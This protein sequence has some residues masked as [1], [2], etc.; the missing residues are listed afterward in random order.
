AL[1]FQ[2]ITHPDDL[3]ADLLLLERLNRGE[4]A[5]YRMDKRYLRADGSTVW[6]HLTASA[7]RDE[8]GAPQIYIA[9]VQDQTERR[10][11]EAELR[12]PREYEGRRKPGEAGAPPAA[13][14]EFLA[15]MSHEIRTPL[16]AILGFTSL[17]GERRELGE[18]AHGHVSRISAAGRA[19]LAIV[20][21]I[22][23]FSK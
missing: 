20:N 12:R 3:D 14:A 4:I 1:D 23:D 18:T 6:V 22:L 19:L 8:A 2:T 16:T 9:E 21:D 7:V 5:S 15:N 17:L 13:K 10:A 11:A